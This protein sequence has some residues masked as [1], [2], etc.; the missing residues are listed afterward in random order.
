MQEKLGGGSRCWTY[1][2]C[3]T[4]IMNQGEELADTGREVPTRSGDVSEVRSTLPR[5][6]R[7]PPF[8]DRLRR[9]ENENLR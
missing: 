8:L 9:V 4:F 6:R 1:A 3:L 2:A 7:E 5:R